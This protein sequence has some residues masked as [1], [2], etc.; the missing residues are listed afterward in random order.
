MHEGVTGNQ[1]TAALFLL[2]SGIVGLGASTHGA[3]V[4]AHQAC[5]ELVEEIR[6]GAL[7]GGVE[8]SFSDINSIAVSEPGAVYVDDAHPPTLRQFDADG[9]FVRW[10]GRQ[11]EGPGEFRSIAGVSVL[12]EGRLAVWDRGSSRITV[13]DADGDHD[14]TLPIRGVNPPYP[15]VDRSFLTDTAGN[16]H[17]RI[18]VAAASSATQYGYARISPD[19]AVDTLAPPAP[20]PPQSGPS[21]TIHT[22]GGERSPF[23]ERMLD[24]LSPR[25][26]LVAGLNRTYTFSIL[27]PAG[28][29]QVEPERFRP[30]EVTPGERAEW[31]ARVRHAERRSG[32]SFSEVPRWKPAYRDLWVDLDGRIWVHRYV[33][34][35][36]RDD[37]IP[38]LWPEYLEG[39]EPTITWEEP[40]LYDVFDA[41]GQQLRCVRVPNDSE[42]LA[43]RG[44]SVWGISRGDLDEQYVIRWRLQ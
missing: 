3:K 13:Y 44:S 24:A 6:I 38:E 15:F 2:L 4:A 1:A 39:T 22:R 34:A 32:S 37:P 12:P 14:E 27:D 20:S 23:P 31:R 26:Y 36:Q 25:G 30:V 11:G 5:A 29:I 19:G 41:H 9:R 28:T 40:S 10:I 35:V 17:L 21:I 7:D 18:L 43:S 8:Y 16:Y 42:V 33:E